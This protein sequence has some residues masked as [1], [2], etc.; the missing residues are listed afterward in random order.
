MNGEMV[1]R[2]LHMSH[3]FLARIGA[4]TT[5]VLVLLLA[6][7]PVAGQQAPAGATNAQ[8]AKAAPTNWTPSRTLW[9]DPDLQGVYT[10]STSTPLERPGAAANRDAYTEAEIAAMEETAAA[11]REA[12]VVTAAPGSLGA[13]Y[14]AFWTAHEKGRL[15]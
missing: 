10:Y 9:G 7:A 11:R 8:T 5:V 6:Q 13:S 4:L 2:R 1:D 12:D 3:R 15:T 14:N